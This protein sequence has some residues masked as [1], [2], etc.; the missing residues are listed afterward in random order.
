M[1]LGLGDLEG[2]YRV[3]L[4]V[5]GWDKEN[6]DLPGFES[7]RGHERQQQKRCLKRERQQKK[8][9]RKSRP[10]AEWSKGPGEKGHRKG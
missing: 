10:T 8:D 2:I 6:Q 4:N 9:E 7:A 1:G 5:W 3:Y